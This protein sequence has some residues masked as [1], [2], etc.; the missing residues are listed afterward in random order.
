MLVADSPAG[1][2]F[3]T[4]GPLPPDAGNLYVRRPADEALTRLING[5]EYAALI[6]PRLCGKSSMLLRQ[7]ARLRSSALHI[8]VYI[9]LGQL[10]NLNEADWHSHLHVQIARQTDGLLPIPRSPAPHALALQEDYNALEKELRGKVLVIMLDQ[11]ETTPAEYG[12]AFF[13]TLREMFVNRWMRPALQNAIFVLAG[14]FVPD[15]LIKDPAI[16]PSA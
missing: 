14:R 16:S 15:E 2:W 5:R 8:P 6:G 3:H 9:S 13:A 10:K 7:W 12:S 11:I 1:V 4:Q